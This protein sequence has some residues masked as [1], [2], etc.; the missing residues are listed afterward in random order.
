MGVY[1]MIGA[2]KNIR[3]LQDYLEQSGI[4]LPLDKEIQSGPG[5][6]L[7]QSIN[8]DGFSV[9]NRFAI[10]PMEGWD[11]TPDGRPTDLTIRRWRNFGL[12]GAKLIWGGEA[13]AVRQ[14]GRAN[15]NQL[16]INRQTLPDL[17]RLRQTVLQAHLKQF[18]RTDDLMIG[19]QLT[20][21][22]RWSK[23]NRNDC[24]EPILAY[25]HPWLNPRVGLPMRSG[26]VISDDGVEELVADFI[27]AACLA[28]EA[29]FDFVDVKHCHG[30]LGHEFL[31]AIERSG[32]YGGNLENR[33]RFA[34]EIIKGI[35][36]ATPE[37]KVAV[38]L[39][40]FDF[41]PFHPAI[42]HTGVP[43]NTNGQPYLYAFGGDGSGLGI[44]LREPIEFLKM[45]LEMG[46]RMMCITA[47]SPYYNPHI[48][49]PAYTPPSDGYLPPEDPL[50]GVSRQIMV[51]AQLKAAVPEMMM[52]GSAYSCL[53]DWLANVAQ[54][55]VRQGDVDLVGI[56][57]MVLAYPQFPADVLAGK[58]MQRN[59]I[60]RSFSD[61]TTA[62]RKGLASGCYPLDDFYKHSPEADVLKKV[63]KGQAA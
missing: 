37:F 50:L 4:V 7:A 20:H 56:G 55:A 54:A 14:D 19:L 35:R 46:V 61:C 41:M 44:D 30:Y 17:I 48:Q 60:C 13:T 23:S 33:T 34:S 18:G 6:P 26:R 24:L 5:G 29:G 12:S 49:R 11:G 3:E 36:S 42:N 40:A 59:R 32:K 62:P 63:K 58:P 45:L 1:K 53:Q 57:R 16:V 25:D 52:V 27:Q 38:R 8:L 15:P 39:S 51:S 21:S 2:M 43:D 10:L 28:Q 9:G 47:G 22:G 31:S